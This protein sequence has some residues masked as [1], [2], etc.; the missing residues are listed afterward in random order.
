VHLNFYIHYFY[1]FHR[2]IMTFVFYLRK[3]NL[4]NMFS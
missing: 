4:I 1:Y 3:K 2:Q